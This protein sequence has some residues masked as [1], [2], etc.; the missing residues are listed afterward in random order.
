MSPHV[1]FEALTTL[2]A[3]IVAR[4]PLPVIESCGYGG[5]TPR[6]LQSGPRLFFERLMDGAIMSALVSFKRPDGGL[7]PGYLVGPAQGPG[8]VVIQEWWGLND[9]IKGVAEQLAGAGYRAL[10]PDLFRGKMAMKIK[11]AEHLMQGINF[12]D[13]ASQDIRGAV[14]YLKAGENAKVGVMGYCMGGALA[15][16]A[17]VFIPESSANI[18][19]Y[20]YAPL[21]YVDPRKIKAPLQGHFGSQDQIVGRGVDALEEKLKAA[22]IEHEFYRYDAKHAFA[23]EDADA[24]KLPTLGYNAEAAQ[25]AWD[26]TLAFLARHLH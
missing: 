7:C 12:R 17:G 24:M 5:L 26:R 10:V 11:E 13:A 20:G 4:N 23:N 8:L 15:V 18:A 14:Q 21:D 2:T 22:G 9:H 6:S 3:A 19:W 1:P 25:L 16:L